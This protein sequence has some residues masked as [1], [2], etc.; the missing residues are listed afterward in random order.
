MLLKKTEVSLWP[1]FTPRKALHLRPFVLKKE[2]LSG[3]KQAAQKQ[4]PVVGR[5]GAEGARVSADARLWP[6]DPAAW[7]TSVITPAVGRAA[8]H[9]E[10]SEVGTLQGWMISRPGHRSETHQQPQSRRPNVGLF[11]QCTQRESSPGHPL[12]RASDRGAPYTQAEGWEAASRGL[13][14]PTCG[15]RLGAVP[16]AVPLPQRNAGV[17]RSPFPQVRGW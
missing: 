2:G 7:W 10:A 1:G 8:L 5:A 16:G 4:Q 14:V 12:G 3:P 11:P 9:T 6:L 15:R 17:C 13:P